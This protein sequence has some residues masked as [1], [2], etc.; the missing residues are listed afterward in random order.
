VISVPLLK[1]HDTKTLTV[2]KECKQSPFAF[3]VTIFDKLY[4]RWSM[5]IC[6]W[7]P[8]LNLQQVMQLCLLRRLR[9]KKKNITFKYELFDLSVLVEWTFN[10]GIESAQV[11]FEVSSSEFWI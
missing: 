10:G 8:K 9:K 3:S 7:K 4:V 1:V 11:S 5:F 6:E 2:H